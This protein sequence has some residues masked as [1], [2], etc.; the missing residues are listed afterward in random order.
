MIL[1]IKVH[2]PTFVLLYDSII[3]N[4]INNISDLTMLLFRI[5]EIFFFLETEVTYEV[6]Y[7]LYFL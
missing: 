5:V 6:G 7:K 1:S 2:I 3:V 4:G